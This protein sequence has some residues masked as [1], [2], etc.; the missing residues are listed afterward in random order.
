MKTIYKLIKHCK[1]D[2]EGEH[3]DLISLHEFDDDFITL[4]RVR[5]LIGENCRIAQNLPGTEFTMW[6]DEEGKLKPGN[7]TK[8][9]P[10][11][12]QEWQDSAAHHMGW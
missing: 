9:N 5:E 10:V 7:E 8:G 4:S 3:E 2:Y 6:V 12:T 1:P 11:G